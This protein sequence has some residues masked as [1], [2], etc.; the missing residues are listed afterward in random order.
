MS[1][2]VDIALT[3]TET[4]RVAKR[5]AAVVA[6]EQLTERALDWV[7]DDAIADVVLDACLGPHRGTLEPPGGGM[8][9]GDGPLCAPLREF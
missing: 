2:P 8:Q 6:T 9:G 5:T 4:R 7:I 1:L 3:I